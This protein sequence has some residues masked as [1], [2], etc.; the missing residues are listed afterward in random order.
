[1]CYFFFFKQKTAYEMRI[2][3]WSSDVCSSDLRRRDADEG[4]LRDRGAIF[5]RRRD[6]PAAVAARDVLERD[7][8]D[9]DLVV[10]A[11]QYAGMG[12]TGGEAGLDRELALAERVDL[13]VPGA[14][15]AVAAHIDQRSE[16][17]VEPLAASLPDQVDLQIGAAGRE[18]IAV[19]APAD[20][21][22]GKDPVLAAAAVARPADREIGR[23]HV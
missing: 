11:G 22:A 5:E 2:S 8:A 20:I 15:A 17:P 23:G 7:E 21:E 19:D 9:A 10:F 1:M 3:D 6:E 4:A 18:G 16:C 12:D 14:P 13:R